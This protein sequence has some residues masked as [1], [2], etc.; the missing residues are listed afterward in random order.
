MRTSFAW[1]IPAMPSLIVRRYWMSAS[2]KARGSNDAP[3]RNPYLVGMTSSGCV[4]GTWYISTNASSASFQFT[5]RRHANHRSVRNDSTFH[6]S[7]VLAAG[8]MHGR[9][10][11]ASSSRLIHA[12]PPHTSRPH[13]DE[14]DVVRLEVVLGE[15]LSPRDGCVHAVEAVAPAMERAGEPVLARPASL[16]DLDATVAAGVLERA[17]A[18]V[19]GAQHDDRLIEELVLDEVVR[20][21]DL[22]EPARHLPDARPQQLDFHLVEVRVDV[23]LL[24]DPVRVLHRVGHRKRRPLPIR[25]RHAA[26]LSRSGVR[27]RDGPY[28]NRSVQ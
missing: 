8:S 22:L 25:D 18:H 28:T 12:H 10:G 11:G 16:D 27:C 5:G 7:S 13:R 9:N 2:M 4:C 21:G 20:R 6:A 24:G 3:S 17:H 23:A 1:T 19:V 14:V 26:P 15:R